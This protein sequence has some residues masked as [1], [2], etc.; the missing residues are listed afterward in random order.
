MILPAGRQWRVM[1]IWLQM[2]VSLLQSAQVP[3]GNGGVQSIFHLVH[4]GNDDDM[5]RTVDD[6]CYPV[7]I[8]VNIHHL[9]VQAQGVGTGDEYIRH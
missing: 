9:A 3:L 5:L 1:R 4:A 7:A 8:A 6:G 2:Q